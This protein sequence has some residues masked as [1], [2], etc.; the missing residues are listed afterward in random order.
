MTFLNLTRMCGV[1]SYFN[2][3]GWEE[4]IPQDVSDV[5]NMRILEDAVALSL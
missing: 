1:E 4:I 5:V 2:F 3:C